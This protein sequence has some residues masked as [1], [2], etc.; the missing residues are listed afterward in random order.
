MVNE[1]RK[2]NTTNKTN[3]AY[4]TAP[5]A[6]TLSGAEGHLAVWNLFNSHTQENIARVNYVFYT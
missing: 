3:V 2:T 6:M 1:Y 4:R 5:T